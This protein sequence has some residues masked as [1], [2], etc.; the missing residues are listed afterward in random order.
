MAALST[1]ASTRP[2]WYVA[3]F[4][5]ASFGIVPRRIV[6]WPPPQKKK[7]GRICAYFLQV[8]TKLKLDK[9]RKNILDRKAKG[10]NADK[11]KGKGK[12]SESEVA[13]ADVD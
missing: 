3:F 8:I 1:S 9:D 12:F 4:C 11:E 2:T 13:M 7:C 6:P 5:L 10:R